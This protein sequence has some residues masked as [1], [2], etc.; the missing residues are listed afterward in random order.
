MR[1]ARQ[2]SCAHRRTLASRIAVTMART[3]TQKSDVELIAQLNDLLQLD[4]DAVQAYSLAIDNLNNREYAD[5]L[6]RFRGDH[7][8]HIENLTALIR[9]RNGTPIELP[10][11]PSG[12]FKLAMQ[13]AGIAGGDKGILLTFKAN[14]RQVRDKY[15]R[16]AD[17]DFPADVKGVVQGNAGDEQVH[18][19]WALETLD[20]LGLGAETTA[21][22]LEAVVERGHAKMADASE[23]A[24][25]KTMIAAQRAGR[26]LARQFREHPVRS[27]LVA[28]GTGALVA[29]ALRRT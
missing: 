26:G 4:H 15:R 5:T 25:R 27:T 9:G 28:V 6:R 2:P 29:S 7:E 22:K 19:S 14:E 3:T 13:A 12:Q 18:Y 11:V 10:H 23:M 17:R 16:F 24:E 21:G 1:S 8:R 20:D